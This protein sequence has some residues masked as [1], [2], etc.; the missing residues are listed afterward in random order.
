MV[1]VPDEASVVA[2][3]L[4]ADVV[5]VSPPLAFELLVVVVAEE[6]EAGG[7]NAYPLPPLPD[8]EALLAAGWAR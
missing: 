8:A 6:D 7:G 2:V 4:P 1:V 5:V 3:E